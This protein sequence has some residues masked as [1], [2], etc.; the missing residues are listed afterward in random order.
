MVRTAIL[1]LM[2]A[3]PLVLGTGAWAGSGE[4][5]VLRSTLLLPIAAGSAC[6]SRR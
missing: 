2:L 6:R 1:S 4:P 5:L 3:I